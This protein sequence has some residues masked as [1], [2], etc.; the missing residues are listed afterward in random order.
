MAVWVAACAGLIL[1][2]FFWALA[3]QRSLR[4]L[5][6]WA[7]AFSVAVVADLLLASVLFGQQLHRVLFALGFGAKA[8]FASLVVLGVWRHLHAGTLRGVGAREAAAK[9]RA[10]G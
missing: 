3:S 7:W 4:E 10:A 1:A 5:R 6:T 9:R 8:L 2:V